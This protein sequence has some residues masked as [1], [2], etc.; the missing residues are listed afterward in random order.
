MTQQGD[1]VHRESAVAAGT[2]TDEKAAILADAAK[3]AEYSR[4]V[5]ALSV[6]A[7]ESLLA[8]YYRHVAAEDLVHRDPVDVYG[9]AR[10]HY[11]LAGDR[12]QGSVAVNVFTPTVEE[13]GWS[14]THTVVEVV[15]DDMPFLVDSV[16]MELSRQDRGIHLVVHPQLMVRRDLTGRLLEIVGA[17]DGRPA[18]EKGSQAGR[19]GLLE[20]WIH[21]EIDRET[22]PRALVRIEADLRRV[23][24]DVRESVEDWPK[25]RARALEVVD[26]LAAPPPRNLPA[27]EI[28]DTRELLSWLADNHFTFLGYREYTLV[29]EGDDTILRAVPGTGL[30]ILRSDPRTA[31]AFSQMPPE[32]RAKA[33][34]KKLLILTKANSRSTVHRPAYL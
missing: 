14:C 2:W 28:A 7:V 20:S 29:E 24:S 22:D 26:E 10:S 18:P 1:S 4:S 31:T 32:V 17:H 33:R 19:E 6:S 25:L 12:P 5:G 11:R 8:A 15:T 21:V 13:H 34:E 23:L 27:Q 9:A 30:G 16:T 3:V